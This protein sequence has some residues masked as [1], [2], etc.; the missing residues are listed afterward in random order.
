MNSDTL[1]KF[2]NLKKGKK[3]N[4]PTPKKGKKGCSCGKPKCN[5][6]KE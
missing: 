3:K 1:N 2:K 4:E 5:C 6:G